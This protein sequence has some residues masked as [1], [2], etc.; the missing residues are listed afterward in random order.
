M[1][2]AHPTGLE[3]AL[4]N[5]VYNVILHGQGPV[6]LRLEGVGPRF[7]L[8]VSEAGAG[9]PERLLHAPEGPR[10]AALGLGLRITTEVVAAHRWT[11]YAAA[12]ESGAELRIEGDAARTD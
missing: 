7:R 11:L 10:H 8:V 12:T 5:L 9:P 6:L 4:C 1:L 3:R 2:W